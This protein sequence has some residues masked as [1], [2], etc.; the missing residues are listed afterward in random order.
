MTFNEFLTYVTKLNVS[1]N[2]REFNEHWRP[3]A[4]LCLPC[5]VNYD[6]I[7]KYETL[8]EDAQL[9]LWKANVF[10]LV[11]FPK[12][13]ETYSSQPSNALLQHYYGNVSAETMRQ[14]AAIYSQDLALFRYDLD[15]ILKSPIKTESKY[16]ANVTLSNTS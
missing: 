3:T 15:S 12:R 13:E 1:E 2:K 16:R 11:K 10:D 5:L 8:L 9:V 14:I 4:D 7:G 6:L